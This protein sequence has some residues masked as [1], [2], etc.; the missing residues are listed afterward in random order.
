MN[1]V[2]LYA[3]VRYGFIGRDTSGTD[4]LGFSRVYLCLGSI[5]AVSHGCLC[6]RGSCEA[7]CGLEAIQNC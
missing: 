7:S 2:G 5:S 4:N 6:N 1:Y 3:G